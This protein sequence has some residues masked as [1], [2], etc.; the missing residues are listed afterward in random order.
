[1]NLAPRHEI[2]H[3]LSKKSCNF[4]QK[5]STTLGDSEMRSNTQTSPPLCLARSCYRHWCQEQAVSWSHEVMTSAGTF[6]RVLVGPT[7]G[8]I[9]CAHT[10][11]V[12]T[13]LVVPKSSRLASSI[14]EHLQVVPNSLTKCC[15]TNKK[16]VHRG[17]AVTPRGKGRQRQICQHK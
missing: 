4:F 11:P 9:L 16:S 3:N 14:A 17:E 10:N 13:V 8:L 2:L 1:M 5:T 12:P 6:G 15:V 7:W